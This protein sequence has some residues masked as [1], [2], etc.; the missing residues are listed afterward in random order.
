MRAIKSLGQDKAPGPDGLPIFFYSHFWDII[1]CDLMNIF[2]ELFQN[3]V[4]LSRLNYAA[5]I[6]IPKTKSVIK[7]GDLRPISLLNESLKIV[8]KVLANL[9]S[10][11]LN[12][13]INKSQNG[14][15]QGREI[16]DSVVMAHEMIFNCEKEGENGF[17]FKAD[18]EKAYDTTEWDSIMDALAARGFSVN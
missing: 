13:H 10:P 11:L 8:T 1:K 12:S 17:L 9:L 2:H 6:L 4:D 14:F 18:F 16:V 3:L 7:V 15:I 5:I